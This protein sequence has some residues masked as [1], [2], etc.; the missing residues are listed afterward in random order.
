MDDGGRLYYVSDRPKQGPNFNV[1]I[2]VITITASTTYGSDSRE[3]L[4]TEDP[5]H[6]PCDCDECDPT[7][8]MS[9]PRPISGQRGIGRRERLRVSLQHPDGSG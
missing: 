7:S 3:L 5:P 9:I 1:G 2:D 8:M 4:L 6:D